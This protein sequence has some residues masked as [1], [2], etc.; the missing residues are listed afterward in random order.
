MFNMVR[1][2]LVAFGLPKWLWGEALKHTLYVYNRLVHAALKGKTPF[3]VRFGIAPD[4][5]NV[6]EWGSVVYVHQDSKGYSKLE[7][8]A[9][10]ARWIGLD[11]DSNGHRI[12][13]P[14]WR[15]I[16]V[17]QSVCLS[18]QQMRNDK[19]ELD[20]E[21]GPV[22]PDTPTTIVK[23][24]NAPPQVLDTLPDKQVVIPDIVHDVAEQSSCEY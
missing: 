9:L 4:V 24:D 15:A 20:T 19:G 1:T 11:T 6:W 8:H 7:P 14:S 17:K 13:W 12:Y 10:E 23:E 5:S 16:T 3:K 21:I 2:F 18:T 22:I